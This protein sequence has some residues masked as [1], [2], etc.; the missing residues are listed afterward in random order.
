MATLTTSILRPTAQAS[1]IPQLVAEATRT[2]PPL[3]PLESAIAVNPLAG[4]ERQ[5]FTQAV[6]DA[7]R[8]F[9]ARRTLPF[10][11]WQAL[12]ARGAIEPRA[13]RDAVIG[14]FG[15]L[16]PAFTLVGL[17]LSRFDLLN[18]RLTAALPDAD[19]ALA[20]ACGR[21]FAAFAPAPSRPHVIAPTERIGVE[22]L[23]YARAFVA[24]WCGAFFDQS[25]AAM[26]MPG[27]DQGL[28][29]AVLR[30][31]A[32]DPDFIRFGG[33]EAQNIIDS[34]ER[35][36]LAAIEASLLA[37][38]LEG[39]NRAALLR[40]LIARLPGWAGHIRWRSEHADPDV[41]AGAP[42]GMA[43]YLA[44]WLLVERACALRDWPTEPEMAQAD[45][46]VDMAARLATHFGVAPA[47]IDGLP[48]P[49]ARAFHA[50]AAT[51][52]AVLGEIW[53]SA[54]E[55]SFRD[56]L[57]PQL[58]RAAGQLADAPAD[59]RPAAQLVFCIDVRSEPFRRAIEAEG[60]YDTYGYA[61]F[62]G[63]P[64][65]LKPRCG[66][67]RKQL[68]VLL[69]PAYELAMEPVGAAGARAEA[70][71][72]RA[73]A[74]RD[75][76]GTLKSGAAT[77]FSTAE[78]MGPFAALIAI[79]RTMAP[80]LVRKLGGRDA[81]AFAPRLSGDALVSGLPF[82]ARLD[83]ARG[84]FAATGMPRQTAPIVVLAGH[85]GEAVN[86][87]YAAA[88]DCGACGGHAG[89]PN[90]RA[91]AA[92][93]NDPEVRA[94]LAAEGEAVP[95]DTLFVAAEHNTTT[96]EVV[97]FDVDGLPAAVRADLDR[98]ANDLARAGAMNRARRAGMLGTGAEGAFDAAAHWAEVRPEWGLAR[99]AAFIVGPRALT[100][101]IDLEG[102]AFLHSY[103]WRIDTED[104]ALALILT[105]PM[106]V[107]QWIN[108][109]YLFSTLDNEHYGAG[110]KTTHNVMG[111]IGVVQGN[112]GD[113]RV[114]LP[115]QSLFEDDGTPYHVPQRLL[116]IVH[117]PIDKVERV[118][119]GHEIL[120]RLFGNGW[121]Q[122][123]VID[124]ETGKAQRRRADGELAPGE[125]DA[126]VSA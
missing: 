5:D 54:A 49:G 73:G 71:A 110:D 39:E 45:P 4:F 33:S 107:A 15:G 94:G 79:A 95:A 74:T 98:L 76:L 51:G 50:I 30:L 41:A 42:A 7:A 20:A 12:M 48:L 17:D 59:A 68:P 90:A 83:A 62:F 111:G 114:G 64:V 120:Q 97:L 75:L 82:A 11:Q 88:L 57:V 78:A 9:G 55:R 25:V 86:N 58:E 65:A 81:A 27:R 26:P 36:P 2:V 67:R 93:L 122:L 34:A 47:L 14:H 69:Q 87:P 43:D 96:D 28:Y 84:F 105:A 113:L 103:D 1:D 101:G 106:V 32:Q 44:L 52:E 40:T 16:E 99:N 116:T 121:V 92:V 100:R 125:A 124:P 102:R 13:L 112:G 85:G 21:R 6:D 123:V 23:G 22:M 37:L 70:A 77:T 119:A 10:S 61:G 60:A 46:A 63:L 3:W 72:R 35:E 126:P 19:P 80:R 24:K 18:A 109:Q 53:L 118:I 38:G 115:R 89:G 117:A 8:L 66:H 29:P 91:M 108:C 56:R 104:A 31:V